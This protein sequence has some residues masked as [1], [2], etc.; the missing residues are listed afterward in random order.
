[1]SIRSFEFLRSKINEG[2]IPEIHTD[3]E[4]KKKKDK[5]VVYDTIAP[6][7]KCKGF[8]KSKCATFL[9]APESNPVAWEIV[10]YVAEHNNPPL[11]IGS[12]INDLGN[13]DIL[14][15]AS[16][17]NITNFVLQNANVTQSGLEHEARKSARTIKQT[18]GQTINQS[19]NQS[20]NQSIK[21]T[22]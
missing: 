20:I 2:E 12:S 4:K 10:S 19:V 3:G 7:P 17:E 18:Y 6:I 14:P 8:G 15:M 16:A 21:R 9:F 22:N 5:N 13:Y 11:T 1:M